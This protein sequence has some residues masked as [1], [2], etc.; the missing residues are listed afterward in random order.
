AKD[1]KEKVYVLGGGS[2]VLVSDQGV[3]GLVIVL[4][5]NEVKAMGSRL[6]CAGG[7]SLAYVISAAK[8]ESLTGLEWGFGIPK[9]TIGG[10]VRGN[11]GAFGQQMG[12]IVET[13]EA[14]NMEKERFQFFSN[15]DCQFGYRTSIFKKDP[16]FIIWGVTLKMEKA[17]QP[18]IDKKIE[19]NMEYRDKGQPKLPSAGSV[20]KNIFFE[21]IKKVNE[22]L[23]LHLIKEKKVKGNKVGAGALIDMLGFKGRV[24]GGAKVSLEHA[25]F[26]VNTGRATAEDVLKLADYIQ[27]EVK[28]RFKVQLE[29]EMQLMGFQE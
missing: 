23:A 22:E 4:K 18:E 9:A 1:A 15:T 17:G 8:R 7:A 2:N 6:H 20:F 27:K 21:D 11:A 29:L 25:N 19:G 16:N 13:V 14:F 28:Q 12:D 10:S 5:N 24:M 3:N 26:I